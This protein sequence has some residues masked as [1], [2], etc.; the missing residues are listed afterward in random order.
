MGTHTIIAGPPGS[1]KSTLLRLITG[2]I[3]PLGGI[4]RIGARDATNLS[5]RKRPILFVSGLADVPGCWSVQ[6][7]LVASIARRSLDRAGRFTELERLVESW[8]LAPLLGRRLDSLSSDERL[9]ARIASIEGRRPA[10]L[11]MERFFE[12]SSASHCV[13]L[14]NRFHRMLRGLGTTVV[15]ELSAFDEAQFADRVIV[16]DEGFVIQ[17]GTPHAVYRQPASI[18]AAR[19]LGTVN[20]LPAVVRGRIV[21]TSAG[22]WEVEESA[23]DGEGSALIRPEDLKAVE[24]G[25]ESDFIFGVEEAGFAPGGWNLRGFLPGGQV[26]EVFLPSTSAVR[27]GQL[28][29]LRLDPARLVIVRES[30]PQA[31]PPASILP[32]RSESR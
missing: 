19:A 23:F 32:S 30:H 25:D 5:P 2:E 13:A 7:L 10:V 15:S 27:K 26:L 6:H 8:S 17:E 21:E 4:V 11:V 31:Q 22:M 14:S 12:S 29:P 24:P 1:G 28:I 16:I 9:V 20:V 18:A 3:K